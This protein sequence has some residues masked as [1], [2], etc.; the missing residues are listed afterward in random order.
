MVGLL[1]CAFPMDADI[2]Q[3]FI[4]VRAEIQASQAALRQEIRQEIR[5]EGSTTR[6]HFDVVAESLRD[7]IRIIAEGL[8]VLD[9][10]VEAIR[11]E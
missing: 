5:E 3:E 11:R 6:R 7:D 2:K 1:L 10:K 4:A 8:V 9:A